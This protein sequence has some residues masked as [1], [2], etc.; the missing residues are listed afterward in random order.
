VVKLVFPAGDLG[1][2][3]LLKVCFVRTSTAGGRHRPPST[4]RRARSCGPSG[5]HWGGIGSYLTKTD[6]NT[7]RCA[8]QKPARDLLEI[9]RTGVGSHVERGTCFDRWSRAHPAFPH[10]EIEVKITA[11]R[12]YLV[13]PAVLFLKIRK[14]P[15]ARA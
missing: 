3:H 4:T 2:E 8:T 6:W 12:T 15:T 5:A 10:S 11:L 9:A 13:P 7:H 1:L 14:R